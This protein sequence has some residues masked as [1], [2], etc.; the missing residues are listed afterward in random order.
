MSTIFRSC[1]DARETPLHLAAGSFKKDVGLELVH[2]LMN[3]GAD[4]SARNDAGENAL[5]Y[6][7]KTGTPAVLRL[8]LLLTLDQHLFVILVK[9]RSLLESGITVSVESQSEDLNENILSMV[10]LHS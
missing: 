6:A 10:N 4:M 5:H 7:M 1:N 3:A 8:L 2:E 9:F